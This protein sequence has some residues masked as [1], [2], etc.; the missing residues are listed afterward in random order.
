MTRDYCVSIYHQASGFKN[1]GCMNGTFHNTPPLVIER[2]CI[3]IGGTWALWNNLYREDAARSFSIM[4]L[5]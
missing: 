2:E 1:G 3:S 5:M 4:D